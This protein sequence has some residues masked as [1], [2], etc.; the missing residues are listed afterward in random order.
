VAAALFASADIAIL[1]GSRSSCDWHRDPAA[2]V[3]GLIPPNRMPVMIRNDWVQNSNDSYWLSNPGVTI[4]NISRMVG[5]INVP[6]RLRTRVGIEE[7]RARLSGKDGLAGDKMGPVEVQAVL[8]RNRNKAAQLVVSDLLSTCTNASDV[9]LKEGCAALQ[10]WDHNNNIDSRGAPLFKEF[11]RVAS[12]IPNVWR[13]PFN[14]ADPVNT[15][16]GLNLGDNVVREKVLDALLKSVQAIKKAGFKP[17]ATLGTVQY[18]NTSVGGRIGIH[19]GAEFEGVLN[20]VGMFG[21]AAVTENGFIV[22]FGSSYL[23]TVTFDDRGPLAQGLLTY[24]QSSDPASPHAY[25]Q[26]PA[27]SRKQWIDLPFH[28]RDIEAQAVGPVL[29]LRR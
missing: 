12:E 22:D 16:A 11:W 6:Q 20:K 23:Q 13:V 15:P 10:G 27:F 19:G 21:P 17:D 24:G 9:E 4:P 28:A 8:F 26:L 18:R 14:A 25:D 5:Q 7:I 2:P 1:D 29:Q 3:P